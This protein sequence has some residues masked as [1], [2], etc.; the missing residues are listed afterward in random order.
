MQ[1]PGLRNMDAPVDYF[2]ERARRHTEIL[3]SEWQVTRSPREAIL[4][5]EKKTFSSSWVV[6]EEVFPACLEELQAW[7]AREFEDLDRPRV[8]LRRFVW[9]V[10]SDW[11]D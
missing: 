10:F 4:D 6:G 11:R 9:H 3:G 1:A 5:V 7:A 8:E 2:R